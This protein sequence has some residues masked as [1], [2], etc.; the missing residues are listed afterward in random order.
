MPARRMPLR[1]AAKVDAADHAYFKQKIER[2]LDQ[3]GLSD[4]VQFRPGDL[5]MRNSRLHRR[6]RWR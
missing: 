4:R 1:I 3:V 5:R 6:R 2:L